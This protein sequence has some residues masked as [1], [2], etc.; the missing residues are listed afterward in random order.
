M[1]FCILAFVGFE[2]AAPLG[3]ETREPRSTIRGRSSCRAC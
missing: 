3:E 2:A 1:V